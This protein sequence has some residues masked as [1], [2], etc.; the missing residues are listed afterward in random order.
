MRFGGNQ[1]EKIIGMGTYKVVASENVNTS[2]ARSPEATNLI[3]VP[4]L[5]IS[6]RKQSFEVIHFRKTEG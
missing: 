1:T 2:E 6:P 3:V 5:K 4:L